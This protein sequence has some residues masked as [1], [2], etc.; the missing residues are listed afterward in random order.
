MVRR[1]FCP[2]NRNTRD[3]HTYSHIEAAGLRGRVSA[4]NE[5]AGHESSSRNCDKAMCVWFSAYL[6][7]DSNIRARGF[8]CQKVFAKIIKITIAR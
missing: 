8:T 3:K 1:T 5:Y 6:N 4:G 2:Q 7:T